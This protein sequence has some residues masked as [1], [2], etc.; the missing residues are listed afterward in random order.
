MQVIA[1]I[2]DIVASRQAADRATLQRTFE[3]VVQGLNQT[4][5]AILSPY[6]ITLG[7]EFQAVLSDGYAALRDSIK[8]LGEMHPGRVRFSI[9]VGELST[10]LKN[11]SA[12][13]MDGPAF[14]LARDGM[15]ALKDS[16]GTYHVAGLPD[17]LGELVNSSLR[18]TGLGMR[19]WRKN[20]YDIMHALHEGEKV[21]DIS[22]RLGISDK[23]IYKNIQ[24]S[25]MEDIDT[26]YREIGRAMQRVMG[27]G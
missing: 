16:S 7:D 26:L 3:Q 8:I 22:S 6:T 17:D 18:I 21:K 20:R 25:G 15:E 10:A 11:D 2:G 23:A 13:G 9:A 12:L 27:T 1:V 5:N 19:T 14:H 4:Q 24:D